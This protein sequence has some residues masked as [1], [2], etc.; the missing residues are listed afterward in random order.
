MNEILHLAEKCVSFYIGCRVGI[1][2]VETYYGNNL[3]CVNSAKK[4]NEFCYDK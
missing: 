4:V 2:G 1:L 3:S